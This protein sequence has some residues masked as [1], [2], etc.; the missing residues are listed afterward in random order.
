MKNI[1]N[2]IYPHQLR[3]IVLWSLLPKANLVQSTRTF[4][5]PIQSLLSSLIRSDT[6]F[7]DHISR[8][9]TTIRRIPSYL[10]HS[11]FLTPALCSRR[12]EPPQ[13]LQ[14]QTAAKE[15]AEIADGLH[16]PP[17]L[18]VGEEIPL[19]EV[20]QSGGQGRDSGQPRSDQRPGDHLVPE[21][22]GE[23]EEGHGGAEEG[24]G[25]CETSQRP[26]EFPGE[27]DGPGDTEEEGYS[28]R[29]GLSEEPRGL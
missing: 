26:Q 25:E 12:A 14:Q 22:E 24:R 17:D 28:Q 16:Q 13:P 27:R 20:P 19:P 6:N 1:S 21:P 29:G 4:S 18:R 10:N 11:W 5:R 7:L 2:I 3:K 23:A 9:K 15:E 8:T